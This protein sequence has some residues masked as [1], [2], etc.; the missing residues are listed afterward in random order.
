MVATMTD[1]ETDAAQHEINAAKAS[2]WPPDMRDQIWSDRL[3]LRFRMKKEMKKY[4]SFLEG[5]VQDD[6]QDG[7]NNIE[8]AIP[9]LQHFCISD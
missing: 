9:I 7:K 4:R 1:L 2:P 6:T 8:D 3:L 5:I